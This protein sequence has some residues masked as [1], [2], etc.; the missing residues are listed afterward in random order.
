METRQMNVRLTVI[1]IIIKMIC[2]RENV[3]NAVKR[4]M[5]AP[6]AELVTASIEQ[7]AT[8]DMIHPLRV[9]THALVGTTEAIARHA[10]NYVMQSE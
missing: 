5:N 7:M 2:R 8:I 9:K 10:A 3:R 4:V 6:R 1:L